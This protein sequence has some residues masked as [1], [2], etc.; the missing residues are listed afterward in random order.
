MEGKEIL[1]LLLAFFLLG[2]GF[3][4]V[5][6]AEESFVPEEEYKAEGFWTQDAPT[7]VLEEAGYP[8]EELSFDNGFSFSGELE[9]DSIGATSYSSFADSQGM[10][11][12]PGQEAE[13]VSEEETPGAEPT[14]TI[15]APEATDMAKPVY[16]YTDGENDEPELTY[17]TDTLLE[18]LQKVMA[19]GLT[20]ADFS[21]SKDLSLSETVVIPAG[22]SLSVSCE[23][24][25]RLLR[26]QD[27]TGSFFVVED[28]ASLTLSGSSKDIT[29]ENGIPASLSFTLTL[30]GQ[31]IPASAPLLSVEK[32]GSLSLENGLIL[33]GATSSHKASCVYLSREARSLSVLGSSMTGNISSS[34]EGAAIYV[35]DGFHGNLHL[36]DGNPV[37]IYGNERQVEGV[38]VP[39]NLYLARA[40]EGYAQVILTG[41]IGS[42]SKI[43]LKV[44]NPEENLPVIHALDNFVEDFAGSLQAFFYEGEGFMLGSEGTLMKNAGAASPSITPAVP[45]PSMA[46]LPVTPTLTPT[47]EPVYQDPTPTPLT[48]ENID[49]SK[50]VYVYTDGEN[51]ELQLTFTVDTLTEGIEKAVAAGLT[52]V[53]ISLSQNLSL[54]ETVVIPQGFALHLTCEDNFSLLRAPTFGESLF[55]VIEGASLTLAGACK[56]LVGADGKVQIEYY[57]FTID[58]QGISATAPLISV[59]KGGSLTLENGLVIKNGQS[60]HNASAIYLASDA[61]S[62]SIMGTSITGNVSTSPDGA[63]IYVE[64]GFQGN[65]NIGDGDPVT[66]SE[67]LRLMGTASIPANLYLARAGEGYAQVN[68]TGDMDSSSKIGIFVGNPSENLPLI[69]CFDGFIDHFASS[70]SAFVYEGEGFSISEEGTLQKEGSSLPSVSETPSPSP[71]PARAP[72]I[73]AVGSAED[74]FLITGL[75]SPLAFPAGRDNVFSVTGASAEKK[76][77][78][79]LVTGDG[80]WSPYYWTQGTGGA[81]SDFPEDENALFTTRHFNLTSRIGIYNQSGKGVL[82]LYFRLFTWAGD[83]WKPTSTVQN[84]QVSFL[85]A[86]ITPTPLITQPTLQATSLS[87]SPASAT[88]YKGSSISSFTLKVTLTG[89]SGTVK[90]KS[91][92][93]KIATVSQKGKV[94]AVK[95]GEA[96]ITVYLKENKS[97]KASCQVTV[98]KSKLTVPSSLTVEKGKKVSIKA[99]AI[100]AGKITYT[101]SNTK[102][103]TVSKAGVV[104]GKKAGKATITVKANGIKKKVKVTV[105]K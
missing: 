34:P 100:P 37:T 68:L 51:D 86:K 59:E 95:A 15:P 102:V 69:D 50:P 87:V 47:P 72:Y 39:S 82:L 21:L 46:P 98:K 24:S 16:I 58:G 65:L 38:S 13:F 32:G 73:P 80:K 41:D 53:D 92:N 56:E 43:G 48:P 28:G 60:S 23:G 2:S 30:D 42:S 1:G 45:T 3:S 96:I 93:K 64:E 22:F 61:Y 76:Y 27:F 90:Y 9:E 91:S 88:L 83:T 105:K 25:F 18:G 35:E 79:G 78:E 74:G 55:R 66:I 62:L 7:K 19:A 54:A 5:L 101:N 33:T 77:P 71:T 14:P 17:T 29:G 57:S 4:P 97:V 94:K 89:G 103:A 85:V 63:A 26:G 70:L 84:V 11:Y 104:K 6:Y 52:M 20:M 36:G 12:V 49:P 10:F 44:G 67:N 31:K 75:E 99:T 40:G 81:R 8:G